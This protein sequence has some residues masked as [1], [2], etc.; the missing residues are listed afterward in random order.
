MDSFI[1]VFCLIC[2]SEMN[3][4]EVKNSIKIN[5]RGLCPKCIKNSLIYEDKYKFSTL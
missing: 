2:G 5:K 4:D 3:I 1:V